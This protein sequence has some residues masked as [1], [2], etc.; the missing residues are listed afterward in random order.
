[1]VPSSSF[2]QCRSLLTLKA[3]KRKHNSNAETRDTATQTKP[4]KKKKKEDP[5][6][7]GARWPTPQLP[8]NGAIKMLSYSSVC[9]RPWTLPSLHAAFFSFLFFIFNWAHHRCLRTSYEYF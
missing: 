7:S 5:P 9:Q 1:M 2:D 6:T 8:W 3:M 4:G